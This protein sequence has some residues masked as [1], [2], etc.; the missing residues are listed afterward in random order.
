MKHVYIVCYLNVAIVL[1][2]Q[3]NDWESMPGWK[4][5]KNAVHSS[6]AES[7]AEFVIMNAIRMNDP[8]EY[9]LKTAP[10]L[11]RWPE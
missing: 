3:S 10:Q 7:S 11:K 1:A 9:T 4:S 8:P 5:R 2:F 6:G